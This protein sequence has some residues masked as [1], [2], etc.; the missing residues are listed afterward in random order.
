MKYKLHKVLKHHV[1]TNKKKDLERHDIT[2]SKN[3]IILDEKDFSKLKELA[4]QNEYE[5]QQYDSIIDFDRHPNTIKK[6]INNQEFVKEYTEGL[7]GN[8]HISFF[9]KII[10]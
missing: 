1:F 8:F 5:Y 9:Y 10:I 2:F 3:S 4:K 6:N 7:D